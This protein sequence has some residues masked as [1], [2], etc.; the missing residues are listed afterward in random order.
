MLGAANL[1]V[2]CLAFHI[3]TINSTNPLHICP[4][5]FF[6]SAPR[7][8]NSFPET[9]QCASS[10]GSFRAHLKTHLWTKSFRHSFLLYPFSCLAPDPCFPTMDYGFD[11]LKTY[12]FGHLSRPPDGRVMSCP[13]VL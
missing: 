6:Y 13:E 7:L 2:I 9:C 5:V 4:I 1:L 8:W 10:L 3:I 11:Y 12:Y